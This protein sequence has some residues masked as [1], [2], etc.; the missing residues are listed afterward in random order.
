MKRVGFSIDNNNSNID[1]NQSNDN[2]ISNNTNLRTKNKII[3]NTTT[4]SKLSLY[5]EQ[6]EYFIFLSVGSLLWTIVVF[7]FLKSQRF[8]FHLHKIEVIVIVIIPIMILACILK[9]ID[10]KTNNNS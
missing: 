10:I 1:D 2:S 6:I 7:A 9:F 4:K 5:Q 3:H 8:P